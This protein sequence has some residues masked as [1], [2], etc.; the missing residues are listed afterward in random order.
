MAAPSGLYN[1]TRLSTATSTAI[2]TIQV[3]VPVLTSA[4]IT[5][6]WTNQD[7]IT[8]T[9]QARVTLNRCATVGTVTSQ[10]AVP[11]QNGMQA[12]KCVN[13]TA[14]TGVTA[15]IEPGTK[16]AWWSEGFNVV[17]GVMY[18]P[19]PEARVLISGAASGTGTPVVALTF[20]N[21]PA[22]ANYDQGVEWLEYAG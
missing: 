22:A 15:T 13:G 16:T 11:A 7:S 9:N 17:N 5:R 19:V 14:A 10:A 21:A 3:L 1:V 2:T 8:T 12:S 6:S 18:L 20:T 4:E